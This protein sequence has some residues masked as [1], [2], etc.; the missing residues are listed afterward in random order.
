MLQR[1]QTDLE[2]FKEL[3]SDCVCGLCSKTFDEMRSIPFSVVIIKKFFIDWMLFKA[4]ISDYPENIEYFCSQCVAKHWRF[5][6][7]WRR[8]AKQFPNQS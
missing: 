6:R 5:P 1:R 8:L 3:H 2:N 4:I 7:D